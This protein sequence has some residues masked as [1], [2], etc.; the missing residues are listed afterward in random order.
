M[1]F[2]GNGTNKLYRNDG[3]DTFTEVTSSAGVGGSLNSR[4]IIFGDYDNDGDLD[5]Y[6]AKNTGANQLWRNNGNGTFTDVAST[7]GLNDSGAG[8]GVM[9]VDYDL[10]GDLDLYLGNN[11]SPYSKLFRNNLNDSKYLK[12]K[13]TGSGNGGSPKDGTGCRVELWNS[14]GTTRHAIRELFGSEGMGSHSPRIAHFGL[15][16]G[17]GGGSGTYTVKVKFTSGTTVTYSNIVPTSESISIG[18]TTLSQTIEVRENSDASQLDFI[19][20]PGGGAAGTAWATQPKVAVKD[21]YGYI[22]SD[23]STQVTVAIASNP[24]GGRVRCLGQRQ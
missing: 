4:G 5:I 21:Q 9:W 1:Y 2:A 14:N 19:Q 16:S 12:V 18:G 8:Q 23:N 17:W 13:V 6:V 10:D 24:G 3:G 22:V 20:Q 7:Y 15:A 11:G